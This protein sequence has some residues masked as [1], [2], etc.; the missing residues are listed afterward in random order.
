MAVKRLPSRP[1]WSTLLGV[2]LALGL[3]LAGQALEGVELIVI[4]LFKKVAVA[5][6][7]LRVAVDVYA[8]VE[9]GQPNGWVTLLLSLP[10]FGIQIY[11]DFSGYSDM[12]RGVSKLFGIELTR[13]FLRP[14]SARTVLEF[15]QRW[16]VTFTRFIHPPLLGS[17]CRKLG[18]IARKKNGRANADENASIPIIG[19]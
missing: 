6:V 13:N 8:P 4:G 19:Q 1:D 3:V 5:D 14:K 12:A 17:R 7:M 15:W 11:C 16:H 9:I 2:P 18:K 10:A